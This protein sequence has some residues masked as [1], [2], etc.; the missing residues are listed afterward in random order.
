MSCEKYIGHVMTTTI[1]TEYFITAPEFPYT[2]LSSISSLHP[3]PPAT[4]DQTWVSIILPFPEC[5]INEIIKNIV[6]WVW[7]LSLSTMLLRF[8]H[9]IA[10][11][12]ILFIFNAE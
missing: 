7:F 11:I 10:C 12:S 3:Q 4:T 8:A 5:Y 6:I 1:S 9:G 2:S